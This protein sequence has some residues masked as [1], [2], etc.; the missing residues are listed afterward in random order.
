[1]KTAGVIV[2]AWWFTV[3]GAG[4]LDKRLIGPFENKQACDVIRGAFDRQKHYPAPC[5]V[6]E[7]PDTKERSI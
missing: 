1:M 4:D 2:L 7:K 5:W 6:V 3:A